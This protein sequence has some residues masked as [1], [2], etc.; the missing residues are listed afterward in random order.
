MV[1]KV[2]SDQLRDSMRLYLPHRQVAQ[3]QT[4]LDDLVKQLASEMDKSCQMAKYAAS[5][6]ERSS[7]FNEF[8]VK[9]MQ[10]V[11]ECAYFVKNYYGENSFG[12]C[13]RQPP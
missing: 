4:V 3:A 11:T 7:R 5:L 8:F 6:G 1:Y 13:S 10:Q 9:I 2:R 12:T